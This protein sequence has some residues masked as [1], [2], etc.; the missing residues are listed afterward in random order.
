MRYS[1]KILIYS[2]LILKDLNNFVDTIVPLLVK[3]IEDVFYKTSA[4][5]L[6]T[7]QLIL[8]VLNCQKEKL[9]KNN[10]QQHVLSLHQA[11]VTKLRVNDIDQVFKYSLF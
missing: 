6:L 3:S 8:Y 2:F 7:T 11:I 1:V 9:N 10:V 5:A 4:E